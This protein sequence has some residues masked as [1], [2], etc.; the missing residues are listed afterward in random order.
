VLTTDPFEL[1]E[2]PV[3]AGWESLVRRAA[4]ART[5]GD[6]YG[7][8]LVATGRAEVMVDPVLSPWD[9]A[10]FVPI[11]REAGGVFT[12]RSGASGPHGGSG[13]STNG[14]LHRE[15]LDILGGTGA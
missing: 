4:L 9:A 7:H 14:H 3:A 6:C 13:V 2:G 5:W 11:L 15:V 8:I 10:P 12:D 1:L